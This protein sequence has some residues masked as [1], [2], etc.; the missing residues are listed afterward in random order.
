MS[1]SPFAYSVRVSPRARY[2][3]LRVTVDKG[4]EVVIPRGYDQR[5]IPTVLSTNQG[6]V[7]TA[8]RRVERVRR[9]RPPEGADS[10]PTQI[11]LPS[12]GRVWHVE[13]ETTSSRQV[14]VIELGDDRLKLCGRVEDAA[15]CQSALQR[16]LLRQAHEILIPWLGE[17]SRETGIPFVR[18]ALR[19]QKTRWGSCST[20]GT[21]SLNVKLLLVEPDLVRY[22]LIHELCHVRHMNHSKRYWKL[23]SCYYAPYKEAHRRLDVAW[24]TMPRWVA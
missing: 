24:R 5:R 7:Q 9:L 19:K 16:W 14:K 17:V 23:V 8:L 2:L 15:L 21:I 1:N 13:T 22:I 20:R 11:A 6:W 10:I 4:L 12:V 3:R 18:T